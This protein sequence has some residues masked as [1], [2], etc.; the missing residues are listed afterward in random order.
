MPDKKP[1]KVFVIQQNGDKKF[2]KEVGVGWLNSDNS[3]N[4]DL[5]MF[6][7]LNLQLRPPKD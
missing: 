7:G 4:L 3:I 2:W 5:Y 6:P 1:Y